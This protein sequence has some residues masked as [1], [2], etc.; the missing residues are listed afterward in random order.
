MRDGG[1]ERSL[2]LLGLRKTAASSGE[3]GG[4]GD[5]RTNLVSVLL[6]L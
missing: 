1:A 4:R 3:A 5:S 6:P 2:H